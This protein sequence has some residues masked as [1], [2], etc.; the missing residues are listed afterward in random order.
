MRSILT[1]CLALFI[2]GPAS[3]LVAPHPKTTTKKP[4]KKINLRGSKAVARKQNEVADRE[5]LTRITNK[6]QL[7]RFIKDG[8]VVPLPEN[9][10]VKIDPKLPEE[11]RYCLPCTRDF[12]NDMGQK[13]FLELRRPI[14]VNSAVRTIARQKELRRINGNAG[15]I[16][17]P[18][19]TSHLT[20]STVDIAK[21]EEA[22]WFRDYLGPLK[23]RD[24]I[25][26]AEEFNQKVFHV[27]IFKSYCDK[28]VK[29]KKPKVKAKVRA[30]KIFSK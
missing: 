28:K 18:Y 3:A 1:L 2:I 26:V 17:G 5:H 9:L 11:Y 7:Q 27:M 14:Y 24:R 21:G 19:R 12:L 23:T 4:A 10:F 13:H 22:E 25:A 20:A 15:P 6:K 30:K 29:N 16:N 8:I